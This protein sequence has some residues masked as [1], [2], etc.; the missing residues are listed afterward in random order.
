[1]R[2]SG[3]LKGTQIGLIFE[4]TLKL[5]H[6]L[7]TLFL[8]AGKSLRSELLFALFTEELGERYIFRRHNKDNKGRGAAAGRG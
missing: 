3:L 6:A 8:M 7:F 1:M 4:V 5:L 2:L